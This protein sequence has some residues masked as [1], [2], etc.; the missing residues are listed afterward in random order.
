EFAQL[1]TALSPI[2]ESYL[3][4]LLRHSG[5][6]LSPVVDGVHQSNLA[7]LETTL[8]RLLD[9]YEAGNPPYR[10]TIRRVV[11]TAKQH[12]R[13]ALTKAATES[14]ALK[15]ETLP[16]IAT[17]LENPSVFREWLKLRKQALRLC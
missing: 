16:W 11:I 12:A 5:V 15:Q 1:R 14:R 9:E 3:R 17:W 7:E 6:P 13:L 2:S 10:A 4:Q 8:L